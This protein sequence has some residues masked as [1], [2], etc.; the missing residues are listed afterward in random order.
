MKSYVAYY[1]VSTTR[2]GQ[3]GLGIEAQKNAV[4][5]FLRQGDRII[6]EYT[7]VESGKHNSR[8]ALFS[9]IAQAKEQSAILIIAKLDRLSRNAAFI[10]TLRDSGVNFVC[11]DMPNANT[12]TIGIFAVIAQHER[13]CISERTKAALAA[14]KAQGFR[15]GTNNLTKAGIAKSIAT[16]KIQAQ[17]RNKQAKE[18]VWLLREKGLSLRKIAERLDE[19]GFKTSRGKRF[20]ATSV[21]RLLANESE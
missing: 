10:F 3:S 12:L 6:A 2:Q 17:K 7:E 18:V 1:R 4:R 13:E 14:K 20:Q 8:S 21:R 15:L 9:A 11:C 19:Y 5:T 16:R